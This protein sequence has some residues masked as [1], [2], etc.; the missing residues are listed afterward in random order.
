V[1]VFDG[2]VIRA[3]R[4]AE[5]ETRVAEIIAQRFG[6]RFERTL[7]KMSEDS[8]LLSKVPEGIPIFLR[9][10][11]H[12]SFFDGEKLGLTKIESTGSRGR[13]AE[14]EAVTIHRQAM[15]VSPFGMSKGNAAIV[16]EIGARFE[17][18]Y[19]RY[20]CFTTDISKENAEKIGASHIDTSSIVV[21]TGGAALLCDPEYILAMVP[22][23]LIA[24]PDQL[25]N[26]TYACLGWLKSTFFIWYCAVHLGSRDIYRVLQRKEVRLPFPDVENEDFYRHFDALVKNVIIEEKRFLDEVNKQ[27][28]R[29]AETSLRE[30][31]RKRHNST[32]NGVCLTMDAEVNKVLQLQDEEVEFIARSIRD[33]GVTDFGRL[34]QM[35]EE[36]E[37]RKDDKDDD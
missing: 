30:K 32:L 5:I 20:F 29:G 12:L 4:A 16:T 25:R 7:E 36:R 33:M 34:E 11:Q 10:R 27:L 35:E 26:H 19:T 3:A 1:Y 6:T 15:K 18:H 31:L 22:A 9:A 28:S 23:T 8:T 24:L 17:E 13:E 21:T 14:D 37:A 2:E